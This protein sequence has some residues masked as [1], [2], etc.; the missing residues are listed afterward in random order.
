MSHV[1]DWVAAHRVIAAAV[2]VVAAVAMIVAFTGIARATD[3]PGFCA[4]ACH[5]MGPYHAA[6]TAGPHADVSCVSCHVDEGVTARLSHKV[7]ALKEVWVSVAGEPRFPLADPAAV[8]DARCVACHDDVRSATAGFD[9]AAHAVKGPCTSCHATAGHTVSDDA[10]RAAGVF[11][12]DAV[13]RTTDS[14]LTAAVGA[15]SADIAGHPDVACAG[16]HQMRA[17]GCATCHEPDHA[18]TGPA[19]KTASCT[20]CHAPGKAFVFTHPVE[21]GAC[22]ACHDPA[23]SHSY[24]GACATCHTTP[25][26]EWAFDHNDRAECTNCHKP[27]SKH[28]AGPCVTCHD[29]GG[30]W[31]FAHPPA[32]SAC[33]SCHVT[34]SKHRAGSCTSCHRAGVSWAFAHPARTTCASCHTRPAG[35]KQGSCTSCH[36]SRTTWAFSHPGARSTCTSCHTRPTKHARSACASCHRTGSSWAFRHPGSSANCT[37]CHKKPSGHRSGACVTCHSVSRWA[38]KHPSSSSCSSCHSAPS[39]HYGGSCG[40]CHSPS[41]SWRS[42]TF[43]HPRVPG[44]EHTSKSFACANCHPSGYGSYSCLKCHD[45]NSGDDDD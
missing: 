26:V 34:P 28:R 9:H 12:P 4:S 13:Q 15:G 27:P 17:T 39:R 6:W 24:K 43:S 33:T 19:E 40:S 30:T 16:C 29:V 25:G 1:R 7:V 45:S 20:T 10:L 32:S 42:A 23:A 2:G 38:F 36:T 8:P 3:Q 31:A 5:E 44:G 21:P 14:S 22:D 18:A 35:H 37:S 41:K 11:N